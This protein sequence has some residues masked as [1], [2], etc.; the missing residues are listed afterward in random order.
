MIFTFISL[1]L[2]NQFES[3]NTHQREE[4]CVNLNEKCNLLNLTR[5]T[6]YDILIQMSVYIAKE[7]LLLQIKECRERCRKTNLSNNLLQAKRRR[8]C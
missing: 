3:L 8:K 7:F 5:K 6:R 1:D 4:F 2:I